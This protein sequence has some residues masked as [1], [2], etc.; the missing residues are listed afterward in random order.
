[1][2]D[3]QPPETTPPV[4]PPAQVTPP[5]APPPPPPAPPEAFPAVPIAADLD[6]ATKDAL[7][8]AIVNKCD[9]L[10]QSNTDP[11]A[12]AM[13]WLELVVEQ[14][15]PARPYAYRAMEAHGIPTA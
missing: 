1:M 4:A 6:D 2:S 9:E 11:S 15:P 3:T 10:W 14:Q 7:L 12:A 8:T 5:P 13:T